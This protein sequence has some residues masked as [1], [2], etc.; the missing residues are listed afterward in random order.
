VV[1]QRLL[2]CD[3]VGVAAGIRRDEDVDVLDVLEPSSPV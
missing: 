1:D 2:D 3:R